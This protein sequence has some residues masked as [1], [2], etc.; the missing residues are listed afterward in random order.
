MTHTP[1]DSD[2]AAPLKAAKPRRI[3]IDARFYSRHFG[4][5]RYVY[6]LVQNVTTLDTE[7]EYV[8]F[9]NQP[10]YDEFIPS[11]PGVTKVLAD[12]PHYSLR[13]QLS[14]VKKLKAARLDL[15]HFTHF[16]API[17][18]R[19]PS[20]VTIHDLTL[21]M[22]PE[23][24]FNGTLR[25][26]AYDLIISS[27]AHRSRHIIAV[28]NNTKHDIVN[29]LRIPE[30]KISV[31]YPGVGEEF[32]PTEDPAAVADLRERLDLKKPYLLYAGVW[33]SHKNLINLIRAFSLLKAKHDFPGLL[34]ITGLPDP[35]YA[36]VTQAVHHYGLNDD[37]R[38]VGRVSEEDLILLYNGALS[39]VIPSL[40]EGFGL[41]AL[42]AFACG[43]PVCAS[44]T[45]CLPEVCGEGNALFFDP[46]D[47][48][49]I[50]ET[51]DTLIK[52]PQLQATLRERGL[53]RAREFSW[54][55]MARSV[56]E[57]YNK[58]LS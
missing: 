40:Y 55:T 1:L 18:Y 30:E 28:S 51:L 3:G 46:H 34:A 43:T 44:K 41:P 2:L 21:S 35:R 14:F 26:W 38:F 45:S 10:N 56:L 25:R 13:E 54:D 16:N 48:T 9:L 8:V 7:N 33:R 36:E 15:M 49:N 24:R 17:L 19:G 11:R 39:Y 5:G 22:Y 53:A 23:R 47:P 58:A 32:K 27:V 31:V 42:E 50:A 37:V 57:I 4:I 6:E 52:D 20:V 12:A 29:F